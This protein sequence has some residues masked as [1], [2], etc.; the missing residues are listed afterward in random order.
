[1][2]CVEVFGHRFGGELS[3]HFKNYVQYNMDHEKEDVNP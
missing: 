2:R 3:F 1:M